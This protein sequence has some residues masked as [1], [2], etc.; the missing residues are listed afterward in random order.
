MQELISVII[1]TYNRG[2]CIEKAITS[3]LNQT[4]TN[5]EVIIVDDG[6]DDNTEMVINHIPDKRIRYL[7][8]PVNLG[9]AGSRNRGVAAAKGAFVAFQDSD[10]VW[11]TDKLE[12]QL[13]CMENGYDLVF[14]RCTF[15]K[16][17]EQVSEFPAQEWIEEAGE[18]IQL[19]LAGGNGID[20]ATML[21]RKDFFIACGG[22]SDKLRSYE[23]WELAVR[24][25]QKGSIGFVDA[26]LVKKEKTK[27]GVNDI[28]YHAPEQL[29]AILEIIAHTK[30]YTLTEQAIWEK[31]MDL[32]IR[33]CSFVEKSVEQAAVQRMSK[34]LGM[35]DWLF[36][37]CFENE[38]E[39]KKVYYRNLMTT[40][41]FALRDSNHLKHKLQ[42]LGFDTVVVYG[43]GFIGKL[44]LDLL[45]DAG[46]KVAFTLDRNPESYRG[47]SSYC[48]GQEPEEI[49][50]II[51]TAFDYGKLTHNLHE[52]YDKK[53]TLIVPLEELL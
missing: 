26:S 8:N 2:Y 30:H 32:L 37:R 40:R 7:K 39:C 35:E 4:Y 33:T 21:I 11:E 51:T 38:K 24:L 44:L 41:L 5:L 28:H 17:L 29:E 45:L 13:S 18:N 31:Q 50:M 52:R 49:D 47:I 20:T 10:D 36:G 48:M 19:A 23:D 22:F 9:P 43:L 42:E 3:V 15:Y 12:K 25:S 16:E 27:K 1:P 14:S 34:I 46:I 53:G 6:S